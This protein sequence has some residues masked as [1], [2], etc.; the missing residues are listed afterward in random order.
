MK[1]TVYFIRHAP[2]DTTQWHNQDRPL[3]ATG[4]AGAQAVL[5]TLKDVSFDRFI[6]SSSPRAIDT[7]K[8]LADLRQKKVE[9]YDE[10]QELP[11]RGK[12]HHLE[13]H[14]VDREIKKV[15]ESL[16]YKLPG[17]KS[18]REVEN[19]GVRCFHELMKKYEGEVIGLGTHGI[20]MTLI[21]A[22]MDSTFGFEFWNSTSKPDIYKVEIDDEKIVS[23]E[24]ITM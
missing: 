14:E 13:P 15:F 21:F 3:T 17:G 7:I 12:E 23:F 10:L 19:I 6:S 8:P 18:R 20:I 9:T 11:L 24:R 4:F 22:S 5:E 16:D 1:T 2:S